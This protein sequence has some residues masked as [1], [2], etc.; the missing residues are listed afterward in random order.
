MKLV[1]IITSCDPGCG[2]G[3]EYLKIPDNMNLD[4]CIADWR[5]WYDEIYRPNRLDERPVQF[6]SFTEWLLDKGA[7]RTTDDDIIFVDDPL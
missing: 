3:A 1:G 2:G 4:K 5:Q 7:V 6:I